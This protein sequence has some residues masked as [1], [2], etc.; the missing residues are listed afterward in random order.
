MSWHLSPW[1]GHVTLVSFDSCQLT[2]KGMSIIKLSTGYILPHYLESHIG[3]PVCGRAD[4]HVIIKISPMDRL[5]NFLWCRALLARAPLLNS[6]TFLKLDFLSF[7]FCGVG[8]E[9]F[10]SFIPLADEGGGVLIISDHGFCTDVFRLLSW[11]F[12]FSS[13][14]LLHISC[15]ALVIARP[16]IL[17]WQRNMWHLCLPVEGSRAT[18][19]KSLKNAQ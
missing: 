9:V 13:S 6:L 14:I 2:K 11:A 3:C 18:Y 4:D 10:T 17:P 8:E 7:S 16:D 5:T 12:F 19:A 15:N 1:H